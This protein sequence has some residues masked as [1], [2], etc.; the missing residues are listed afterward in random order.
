MA[1][2]IANAKEIQAKSRRHAVR[3]IGPNWYKVRSG[4]TKRVYD[5]VLAVNGGTCTCEWG[6]QRPDEDHRSA[7]SHVVAALN[8]RAATKGRRVS[9]WDSEEAAQR[10]HRPI[11]KI[12]DGLILTSRSG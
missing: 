5:V 12:G 2:S 7:C 6:R 10:Q 9:A 8:Y 4:E 11:L 3:Q 1:R